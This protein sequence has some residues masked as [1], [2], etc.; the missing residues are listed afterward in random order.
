MREAERRTKAIYV[1]AHMDEETFDTD[2]VRQCPVGVREPDGS[3]I[4]SCS[5]NVLY[6]ERDGRFRERPEPPL[7]SLGRGRA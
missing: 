3:N 5:Y 4:P 7:V 1:H 6:R 2:R